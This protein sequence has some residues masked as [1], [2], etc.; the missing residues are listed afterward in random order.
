MLFLFYI[1]V[2]LTFCIGCEVPLFVL[3]ILDIVAGK[4]GISVHTVLR[5]IGAL[6]Q[7]AFYC[8]IISF[9]KFHVDLVL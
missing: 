6:I 4:T 8:V 2:T 7:I 5:A 3:D 1:I 9:F